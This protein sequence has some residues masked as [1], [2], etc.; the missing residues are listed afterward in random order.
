MKLISLSK[1][2]F[3]PKYSPINNEVFE[4]VNTFV[5]NS[6]KLFVLSGAGISTESGIPDYR[7]EDV[8]LYARTNHRLIFYFFVYIKTNL[9]LN[10]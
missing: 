1:N 2:K 6:N 5:Q 4:K 7:S 10:F 3:V 9:S 8:G